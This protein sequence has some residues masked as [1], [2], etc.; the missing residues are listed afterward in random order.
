[1]ILGNWSISDY[2]RENDRLP[3]GKDSNCSQ[4]FSRNSLTFLASST[5]NIQHVLAQMDTSHPARVQGFESSYHDAQR[6]DLLQ[7]CD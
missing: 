6:N 7:Y 1:M 4:R 2:V 5:F 3:Q